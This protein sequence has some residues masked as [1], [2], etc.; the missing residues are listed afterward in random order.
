M[1]DFELQ[2]DGYESDLF[3]ERTAVAVLPANNQISGVKKL[4]SVVAESP[5]VPIAGG[6]SV[7]SAMG[8]VHELGHYLVG[9]L[10]NCNPAIYLGDIS[11]GN[12]AHVSYGHCAAPLSKIQLMDMTAGGDV[13]LYATVLGLNV[14]S[15]TMNNS[16]RS[17]V[18][19][20]S[21]VGGFL[22]AL[23]AIGDAVTGHAGDYH[24]LNEM[25]IGYMVTI[26][27]ALGLGIANAYLANKT[28]ETKYERGRR[29]RI[30]RGRRMRHQSSV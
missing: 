23:Y 20:L 24:K 2:L 21:T 13:L 16:Y 28:M 26:P 19:G 15:N 4:A 5:V 3:D 18:K 12:L 1:S 27:L 9:L 22:P 6:L 29:E 25:G 10:F 8:Y 14:L 7:I 17:L 11:K 30:E